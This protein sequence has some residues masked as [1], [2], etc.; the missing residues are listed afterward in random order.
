MLGK[1]VT[2]PRVRCT[3]WS[4]GPLHVSSL[5]LIKPKK[6]KV[7]EA[8]SITVSISDERSGLR[9]WK[10][11]SRINNVMGWRSR[12]VRPRERLIPRIVFCRRG[13]AAKL[14]VQLNSTCRFCIAAR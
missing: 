3:L 2:S 14:R 11:C 8:H 1:K 13:M 7:K 9:E 4:K 12:R 10:I 6:A 5:H